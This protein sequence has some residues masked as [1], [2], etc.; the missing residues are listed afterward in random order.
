MEYILEIRF[1]D[2]GYNAII[3]F[4]STFIVKSEEEAKLFVDELVDGFKRIN[5]VVLSGT[6]SR[7]DNNPEL[8]ERQY[9]FYRFYMSRATANVQIEQFLLENPD[10]NKSLFDNLAE[11]LFNGENS[12]AL[13]GKKYNLPVRVM[14]KVARN[15]IEADIFYCTIEHLV[16]KA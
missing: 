9:E 8:R 6:Y 15:P 11:K 1:D 3:H 5:V 13:I 4:V 14:D 16:P 10:Q 2:N 7:I 12:T